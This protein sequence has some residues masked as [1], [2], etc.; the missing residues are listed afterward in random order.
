[1]RV[2]VIGSTGQLG[3]DIVEAFRR[4]GDFVQALT[5]ADIDVA[6]VDSVRSTLGEVLPHVVVNTAAMHHVEKCEQDREGA[7][8]VNALG[9]RNIADTT[10]HLGCTVMHISTDYVFDGAKASPYVEDD[11]PRPL[12]AY[13]ETKLEG[14]RL[15]AAESARYFILR[16]SALY[17]RSPCRGKGGRNFVDLMLHLAKER[18]GVRVI[19]SEVVTPTSTTELAQQIV[20]LSSTDAYG[21]Y[22]AT[23]EGSCSWFEFARTILA[24]AGI[25]AKVEV[26][27]PNE[28]PAKTPR[29]AYS[30]LENHAL[31]SRGLDQFG[32]WQ[33]GLM[34]YL[35]EL[36]ISA[37]K[38]KTVAC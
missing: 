21:L 10:N 24:M 29:P 6:D 23:A 12:N 27:E 5:H 37:P 7:F 9:P 13:G 2:A 14:E 25:A 4:N 8:A 1:M 36:G 18:G 16:T 15:V 31:K 34:E 22:H 26:A 17:G 30:V 35:Q 3:R 32:D 38:Q 19:A 28:F 33:C 11:L 20:T